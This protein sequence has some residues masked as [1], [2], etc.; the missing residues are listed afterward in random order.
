LQPEDSAP[1]AAAAPQAAAPAGAAAPPQPD[2]TIVAQLVS[3][4]FP[5]NGA[6]RA[7]LAAGNASAEAAAEWVF[8]HM[9]DADFDAPLP[10]GDG[11]GA[12]GLGVGGAASHPPPPVRVRV[13]ARAM[14]RAALAGIR[15]VCLPALLCLPP[16]AGPCQPS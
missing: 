13:A 3:M 14:H 11:G 5:E 2:E 8:Q 6:K 12:G 7:A 9:G 15:L 1:P 16:R 4:G 10:A